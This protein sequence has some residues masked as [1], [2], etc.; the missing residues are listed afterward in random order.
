MKKSILVVCILA[1]LLFGV[2]LYADCPSADL[3]GDCYVGLDDIAILA[4]QWLTGGVSEPNIVWVPVN[5]PGSFVGWVSKYETTNDDYC[6]FLNDALASGDITVSSNNVLG[7]VG[8]NGGTDYDGQVYYK[9]DGAGYN[10]DGASN[11]GAA[12]INYSSG[13][14]S[15]DIGF[16]NHPVTFISWYGAAAFCSYYGYRL[17]TEWEWQ[18]VADFN[19]AYTYGCGTVIAN[20]IANYYGST[21]PKGTTAV[22][23]FGVYGYGVC[24]MAGNVME[25]TSSIYSGSNYVLRGG[26]WYYNSTYC[27]VAYRTS[28]LTR[29]STTYYAGFR[30]FRSAGE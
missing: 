6:R 5:E 27:T 30:A 8:S 7:A 29:P 24:D 13:A 20:S 19:G 18:A 1:S 12:R 21:H 2:P 3:T 10:Y 11:G 26:A 16:E 22:G 17:P 9:L 28:Y 15:V 25:W 23:A 14:F 4:A